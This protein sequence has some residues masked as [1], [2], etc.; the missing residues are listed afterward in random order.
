MSS[1][2]QI[3]LKTGGA[4][5]IWAV[6]VRDGQT[7]NKSRVWVV[8]HVNRVYFVAAVKRECVSPK[9]DGNGQI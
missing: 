7:D 4:A 1:T 9:N 8:G 3:W 2:S 6:A 5:Q